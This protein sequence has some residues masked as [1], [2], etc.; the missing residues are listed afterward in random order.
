MKSLYKKL[1]IGMVALGAMSGIGMGMGT[2]VAHA[3]T[4]PT[5]T[6]TH[7]SYVAGQSKVVTQTLRNSTGVFPATISYSQDGFTGTLNQTGITKVQ[8]GT[9]NETRTEQTRIAVYRT[10]QRTV[11]DANGVTHTYTTQV[12]DHWNFVTRN[13][14]T[15]VPDYQYTATY[16]G[17]V[18]QPGHYVTY[19][20]AK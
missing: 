5:Q 14:T 2:T 18:I 17:T 9:H 4:L 19:I 10:V 13:I 16:S 1:A 20:V 11:T 8:I 12:F 15:V 3:G 7:T 6:V